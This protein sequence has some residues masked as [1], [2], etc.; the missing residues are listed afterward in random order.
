[1]PLKLN[2]VYEFSPVFD[3]FLAKRV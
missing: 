2:I 1:M 3:Y